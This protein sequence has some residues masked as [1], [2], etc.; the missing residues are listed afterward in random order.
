VN[1][2]N[3]VYTILKAEVGYREGK[4]T[5]GKWNNIQKYSPT[6]PGLEWSQGQPWAMTLLSW[7]FYQ[8]GLKTLAP[9]TASTMAGFKWYAAKGRS[10][11]YPALGAIVFFG[12][13]AVRHA[14]FVYK[15]DADN[16]Y[17][18]EGNTNSNNLAE[19]NGVHLK[20]R[21]RR[22]SYVYAYGY[23]AYAEGIITA[24]PT[25]KV[26][27][28]TYRETADLSAPTPKPPAPPSPPKPPKPEPVKIALED[29]Q[30]GKSGPAVKLLQNALAAEV[31][32]TD[33]MFDQ[34]LKEVYATLQRSLGYT[35][36]SATGEPDMSSLAVLGKK[37]GFVPVAPVPV[38]PPVPAAPQ[39]PDPR[40]VTFTR[41]PGGNGGIDKWIR[42]ACLAAGVPANDAWVEGYRVLC[43]RESGTDPNAV[44]LWDS[45]A[46]TPAGY[47]KV[48][49]YGNNGT[50]GKPLNGAMTEFQC[51]RG[52]A[53]CVPQ[54]F[55]LY[56][57]PGT[58]SSIYDPVANIAA[59]IGYVRARYE[60]MLDGSNLASKVQQAD[61][62]RPPKGY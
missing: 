9:M 59:S 35:S 37:Y 38:E 42:D 27:R 49:D 48:F 1:Q 56:H 12:P 18:I 53:Q 47:V 31:I 26:A 3:K 5:S 22:D 15:Y 55:A 32:G 24:D 51:S 45:N 39:F 41:Y 40:A 52:V 46:V 44:N 8:A 2:A 23:P 6:V 54:T 61:P 7:A 25:T 16:I 34:S 60:V 20:I 43:S 10:S 13:N 19:G 21:K 28:S 36:D 33:G 29:V 57:V 58:S 4:T 14:G 30:P 11:V 50:F 17:T 62:T